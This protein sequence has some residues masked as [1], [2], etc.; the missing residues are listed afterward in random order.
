MNTLQTL[1]PILLLVGLGTALARI[2]FL[3][4]SFMAD[5]NKLA[6]W[7]ALPA[8]LFRS[9]VHA[10]TPGPQTFHLLGTMLCGTVL[11][12]AA[13]WVAGMFLRLP[14]ASYGTLAQ[15]A[16]RGNLAFIGVPVLA[17]TF[18]SEPN[19]KESF[20]T[21]VIVMALLMAAYN[22]FAVIV[23]QASRGETSKPF[24]IPATKSILANP[25]LISGLSGLPFAFTHTP[26]PLFIDRGLESLA[27][28][29]VPIALLCIGGSL[30][31]ARLGHRIKSIAAAALLKTVA[32]PAIT[33]LLAR[34][35]H[36]P[37]PEIQ[38]AMVL[39]ACPTAAAAYVMARQMDGDES[40]ASGSIVLSTIFA[41]V[42]L[43]VVLLATC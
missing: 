14:A 4:D 37:H 20:A 21:G 6:F 19:G 42:S 27:G 16:F 23:L 36:L 9:V 15:S 11:V 1:L 8:L 22:I 25:L 7:V 32:L 41:A 24:L 31:Y 34:A 3:G 2:R 38:I 43:P 33:I 29:A 17:Y 39:A 40:L 13:G 35:F 18:A 12:G 26:L 30:A 5:L 10:E 28:S